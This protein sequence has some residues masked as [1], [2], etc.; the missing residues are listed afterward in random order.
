MSKEYIVLLVDIK[1]KVDCVNKHVQYF[2]MNHLNPKP[3]E[4]ML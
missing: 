2:E 4:A 3:Q 1:N